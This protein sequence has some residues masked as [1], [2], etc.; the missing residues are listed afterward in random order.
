MSFPILTT[1]LFVPT[2]R[3]GVV[4]RPQL[5]NK[6]DEGKESKLILISAP[7]GYGKSTLLA[8]WISQREEVKVGW[9]SLDSEDNDLRRFFSYLI[10]SLRNIDI[11]IKE[12]AIA[13]L[14]DQHPDEISKL[15]S[16]VINQL[17]DFSGSAFLVLDDYHRITNPDIHQ[18]VTYLLEKLSHNMHLV[19]ATRSDPLLRL[20]KLRAQGAL[21]EIRA[22][23]L[24]F[25]FEEAIQYFNEHMGLA[26]SQPD[27]AALTH[28]TEG[29]IVG[30]QLAGISLQKQADKHQ[31]VQSFAGDDRYIAD[32]LFDEA[33]N[34]Q[35]DH[36]Q[37]FLLHT[38]LLDRFNAPLCE[39]VTLSG[40]SQMVL[41]ELEH[42][43]LFL[44]PLDNQRN[45]Y[46]YH[47]L[48]RDLLQ[49]RLRHTQPKMVLALN[50][51]ASIWFE[52][53][54]LLADSISHALAANDIERVVQ[55]TEDMAIYKMDAGELG[56]LLTWLDQQPDEVLIKY[57]WLLVA[58]AWGDVNIGKFDWAMASITELQEMISLN[59]Y[60]QALIT[61]IQGH[62]A[63]I[64]SYLAEQRSSD[65]ETAIKEAENAL[66]LLDDKDVHLRSF[67]SI[68]WA[69]CLSWQ[70]D[71]TRAIQVLREAGNASKL[72][73]EGQLAV[74]ALSEMAVLQTLIGQL[75][76]ANKDILETRDYA[77][78]LSLKDGRW[79]PSM[80]GLYRHLTNIKYE[81]N[82][83]EEALKSA[84]QAVE[85]CQHFGE[86]EALCFAFCILGKVHFGLREFSKFD[87]FFD[88]GTQIANQIHPGGLLSLNNIRNNFR[89]LQGKTEDTEAFVHERGLKSSDQFDFTQRLEYQN[90]ARLLAAHGEYDQALQV[91]DSVIKVTEESGANGFLIK[92]KIIQAKIFHWIQQPENTLNALEESLALASP[93]GY[94]RTFLDEGE[95]IPQ[96]LYQSEQKGIYPEYCKRLLDE[97]SLEYPATQDRSSKSGDKVDPLSERELEVLQ[98]ISLGL[99]N[100]EIAQELI[101]S[102]S[103]VKSHA[104]NIFSK[105]GVKNR[106]EA[107]AKARLFGLLLED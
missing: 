68:R 39:A 45:W 98:R 84:R 106:T 78:M 83:L 3:P 105:L 74:D 76:Q 99:S 32:Y 62:L 20:A 26:L 49:N 79:L 75:N 4:A 35:P 91:I 10:A 37:S 14:K 2:H 71:F 65:P 103:T 22:D 104:R 73:Q 29:W 12:G 8:D 48:F 41:A 59:P 46:R 66:S 16:Q 5:I 94:V 72:A 100:Q 30:L 25:N 34:R 9:V 36:I 96:L 42:A 50:K 15:L 67:V 88:Q 82:E 60:S 11:P 61:R 97:F 64:R 6:L 89:L 77:E 53:N 44:V 90:F 38:S 21:C 40:N 19:I 13:N 58:R 17:S 18:A 57:P 92:A 23:D 56:A 33:F 31:F 87:R 55:L 85:I 52:E 69:N 70:G 24:R 43:N 51:K 86:N 28:K 63:A 54:S 95:V 27:I 93:E 101:V 1:K 80:G 47:H 102:L 81:R 7:A 107:V